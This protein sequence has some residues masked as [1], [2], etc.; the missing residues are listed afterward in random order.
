MLL[1][2]SQALEFNN[3]WWSFNPAAKWLNGGY[4]GIKA[5][6]VILAKIGIKT[7]WLSTNCNDAWHFLK[8]IMI[9]LL[10]L[11]IIIPLK[12]ILIYKIIG[13]IVLGLAWN[14]PFNL[15]FN[16]KKL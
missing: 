1:N 13:L 12:L 16:N 6:N 15:I 11:A 8:S 14:V 2:E 9:V 7:K 10:A 3:K 5:N 4:G